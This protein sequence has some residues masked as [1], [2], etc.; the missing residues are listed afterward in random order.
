M[1]GAPPSAPRVCQ[2]WWARLADVGP[3]L[4]GLLTVAE[5]EQ[6][7]RSARPDDGRRL[8]GGRALAR[9]VLAELVGTP[10]TALRI[11]RTCRRCGGQH[12][13]PWLPAWPQVQFSVSH[14]GDCIAVA[15]LRG[16][17]VGVDVEEVGRLDAAEVDGLAEYVLAAPERA[18]LARHPATERAAAFTSYWVGKEAVLKATAEGISAPLHELVLP[19]ATSTPSVI[20][21]GP[22]D[23][24]M[25]HPLHPPRGYVAALAVQAEAP[26]VVVERDAGPVLR[27]W[28]LSLASATG[29]RSRVPRSSSSSVEPAPLPETTPLTGDTSP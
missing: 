5:L 28:G 22:S 23:R 13:K 14:A 8:T 17:S 3:H 7:S 9:I 4:D 1:T 26:T 12:G 2:V 16:G 11:D 15:T 20:R 6:R 10:P 19:P 24:L 18:D 25:L 29:Q 27:D 21:W